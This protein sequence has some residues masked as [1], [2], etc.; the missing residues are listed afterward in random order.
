MNFLDLVIAIPLG[1]LM[2][3]GYRR[4][5]IFECALLAGIIVGSVLA[6]RFAH[7]LAGLIGAEGDNVLLISFFVIFAGVVILSLFVGKMVERFVKLVH[8][9]WFNNLAGMLLGMFK[10]MCIVGVLL[11]YVAVVDI[12]EKVLSRGVKEASLLYRP[13]ERTGSHLA[14]RISAYVAERKQLHDEQEYNSEK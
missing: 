8:V 2:F 9:G 10:G 4:G 11:Y 1:Y 6:V 13:V 3:K 5:L 12:H 7:W 14:G